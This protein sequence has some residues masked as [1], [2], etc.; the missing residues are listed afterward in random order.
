MITN[1]KDFRPSTRGNVR[2]AL[3]Q[4]GGL[5]AIA[6]QSP[7]PALLLATA[8][9]F[10]DQ[11]THDDLKIWE[12]LVSLAYNDDMEMRETKGYV[13]VEIGQLI[14]YLGS[15]TTR[16][17]IRKAFGRLKRTEVSFMKGLRSYRQV[18]L[19]HGW[20]EAEGEHDTIHFQLPPPLRDYM[21]DQGHYAYIEL[22]ALP[23][24]R[25][26][27]SLA[28]YRMLAGWTSEM[29][30]RSEEK[31]SL[32]STFS[33]EELAKKI[34]FPTGP[35]GKLHGGKFKK[36]VLDR[37][38]RRYD[39]DGNTLPTDLDGIR[40]FS[41][42]I[43]LD[44]D[45]KSRGRPLRSITFRVTLAVPDHRH[46]RRMS[47]RPQPGQ[48]RFGTMDIKR[49]RVKLS[50]WRRAYRAFHQ[51][52]PTLNVR[53]MHMLWLVALQEALDGEALTFDAKKRPTRRS[54]LLD[55]IE[56]RGVDQACW[57]FLAAE[58]DYPDLAP[59]NHHDLELLTDRF[60]HA[61]AQR[62]LRLKEERERGS[63]TKAAPKPLLLRRPPPPR[64]AL[65][66]KASLAAAPELAARA[67]RKPVASI[68]PVGTVVE[69]IPF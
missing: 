4:R 25:S 22:A 45:A 44:Y 15:R 38:M 51:D 66:A 5:A 18:S 23:Q 69:D 32:L 37:I 39:E 26:K 19:L 6:P 55:R 8:L 68:V 56:K 2:K 14:K 35:H 54:G 46:D 58:A 24:M 62:R 27:Y 49:Y 28:I 61:D 59:L 21:A 1:R 30:W 48:Q 12:M 50:M 29:R 31:K 40:N 3:S 36:Q 43:S 10:G 33:P 65:D 52:L 11:V 41:V 42:D 7:R 60:K 63:A 47:Y 64:L 20:Q 67:I 57:E 9:D 53:E 17:D 16:D 13:A 34:G